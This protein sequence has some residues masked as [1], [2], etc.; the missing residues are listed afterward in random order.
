MQWRDGRFMN[1]AHGL[2]RF[3]QKLIFKLRQALLEPVYFF[4]A[5]KTLC[6][7]RAQFRLKLREKEFVKQ[8]MEWEKEKS[9]VASCLS[10]TVVLPATEL[11]SKTPILWPIYSSIN[12][13]ALEQCFSNVCPQFQACND[14]G[15]IGEMIGSWGPPGTRSKRQLFDWLGEKKH[16]FTAVVLNVDFRDSRFL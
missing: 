1:K 5:G 15:V 8:F 11:L 13:F 10:D 6:A 7:T 2:C 9:P 4:F 12:R 16:C 14:V 3:Y